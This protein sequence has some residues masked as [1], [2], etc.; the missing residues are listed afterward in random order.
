M[1]SRYPLIQLGEVAGLQNGYAFKSKEWQDQG[2]PVVK[3]A[4]VGDGHID[5]DGCAFVREQLAEERY[6]FILKGGDILIG[7]TGYVGSVGVLRDDQV[8]CVLN[9]RV[10]RF[11]VTDSNR[12]TWGY[13]FYVL[14]LPS[15]KSSWER[16][17]A[18]SA[19]PNISAKQILSV[20]MPLPPIDEQRRIAAVL[21]A[22]DDRIE[23]NRRM[24]RTLEAMA[25]ALFRR[26][27]VDFD[28]RDDLVEHEAGPIPTGWRWGTLGDIARRHHNSVHPDDVDPD[29]P[30]IGLGDMPQ[31]SIALDAWGSAADVSS[32]KAKFDRGDI[33]FGKLRPYFKKVGIA[34]HDGIC[35][36]DILVVRPKSPGWYGL[37]LG[38]L[39]YD[40][41]IDFTEKVSTGTRMPRVSWKAMAGFD[42]AL[43][44]KEEAAAFDAVVRPFVGR[45]LANIEHSRTLAALRDALLPKLVSGEL[46]VPRGEEVVEVAS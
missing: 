11:T 14:R 17:A 46:R 24:N 2:I 21:G 3:I 34:P 16:L 5:L 4:N 43:P 35:S 13:L 40:P 41:F 39:T 38:L 9:Q 12:L 10:G 31:G 42:M 29:T 23:V 20:E 33:L 22:L 36:S 19:Q 7:M 30:Y 1:T 28:G 44:P 18:G 8:P 6:N 45:I 26:R 27:F 37:V 32:G 25:Q 15:S